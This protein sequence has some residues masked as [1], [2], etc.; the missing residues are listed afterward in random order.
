MKYFRGFKNVFYML[1]II[2][3]KSFIILN[4]L[5]T[6]LNGFKNSVLIVFFVDKFLN[7]IEAHDSSISIFNLLALFSSIYTLIIIFNLYFTHYYRPSMLPMIQEKTST[8][9][10]NH[11]IE[12]DLESFDDPDFY[13]DYIYAM[14]NMHGTIIQVLD[15]FA[16]LINNILITIFISGIF[17]SI[18]MI[19]MGTVIFSVGV[20]VFLY[21]YIIKINY[22]KEVASLSCR[23]KSDY[24]R[25]VFYLKDYAKELR[26]TPISKMLIE[27]FNDNISEL[28]QIYRKYGV[29]LMLVNTLNGLTIS[30]LLDIGLMILLSYQ[31]MVSRTI[32]LGE[33]TA[34]SYGIWSLFSSL[35]GL[36]FGYNRFPE[37]S[38]RIQKMMDF[39]KREPRVYVTGNQNILKD[40]NFELNIE[41]IN[42][43]YSP[44][45]PKVLE[46]LS[47]KIRPGEKIA[48]VGENGS[49]KSTL[50]K[51]ILGLYEPTSGEI[52]INNQNIKKICIAEYRQLFASVFQDYS[53]FS[54]SIAQ[55]VALDIDYDPLKIIDALR[56]SVFYE[57]ETLKSLSIDATLTREFDKKGIVLSGGQSQ[58]LIISRAF[59]DRNFSIMDEPSSSLD[60][61]SEA[62]LNEII[63]ND[64]TDK[65]TVIISH[66]LSTAKRAD[67]IIVL[68][69]GRIVEEGNH[70]QLMQQKGIYQTMFQLQADKYSHDL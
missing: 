28:L 7:M 14:Q 50:I 32:T 12:S 59:L 36:M 27:K 16:Q 54:A 9:L 55:N 35:N 41:N 53:L 65:A 1:R 40:K 30:I 51:I 22:Q 68:S 20:T 70:F 49:G 37:H 4:I 3:S 13:N 63:L 2:D 66:R 64:K 44:D 15:D 42:F 58:K 62:M 45:G 23:R 67:R 33:F 47:L 56:K 17:I 43:S 8:K 11:S 52:F 26:M 21:F 34:A 10:Y 48:I 46:N 24:Y 57:D 29:K 31:L 19:I 38:I 39:L 60:V 18:N 5:N 25:R 69:K 61:K 6:C